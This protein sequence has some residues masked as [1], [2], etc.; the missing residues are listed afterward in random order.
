MFNLLKISDAKKQI[1]KLEGQIEAYKEELN[2]AEGENN[3]A[4]DF[5]TDL[6]GMLA[7]K[8]V[9]ISQ[10]QSELEDT[11]DKV[12]ELETESISATQIATDIIA[13]CGASEPVE[14]ETQA[15]KTNKELVN[16]FTSLTDPAAKVAFYSKH[17][18][19]LINKN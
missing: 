19:K 13:S 16:E 3:A 11:N 17:R 18:D 14:K 8:D 4:K 15:D 9:E 10:L 2:L 7:E 6:Q 12:D 5:A 1:E